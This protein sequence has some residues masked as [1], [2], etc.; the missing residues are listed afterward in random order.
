MPD[1]L[2]VCLQ[3]EDKIA[4]FAIDA[5]S[6]ALTRQTDL[7]VA[8][9]P[10]VL[11]LSP[12]RHILHVGTRSPGAILSFRIDPRTGALDPQGSVAAADAPTFLATDRTGRYLLSAYY[13]G[14]YAAVH[15]LG[16]DGAVGAPLLDRH[17]TAIG[18]HAIA[19]DPSN[20]FA[21]VPHISRVQDN[22]LEPPKN[23]PGPNFI[24]QFRFD[25]ETGRLI[26]N[27]PFR[28]EQ[29]E[30]IGPRHY[31]FHPDKDLVYFSDEQGCSVSVYRLDTATGALSPVQRVGTLPDGF[32]GRNTC[33]QIHLTPSATFLYV[34][35]R[36]HNSIAGFAV[37]AAT[38]R[39]DPAGHAPTEAVPSAFGLDPGGN[40][41]FAAGT[42]TGRLAAYRIDA[43]T[44]GLT[45][46]ATHDVG[47][48]PAAVL[49]TRLAA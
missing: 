4:S 35:N 14:G 39:L 25:A 21:F 30:L 18:A 38:G 36:G 46:L 15:P 2:F 29:A 16:P 6:G 43:R 40:F 45:P 33:S 19:T 1:I 17:D 20:R 28:V 48:R 22:V 11:A 9:G 37:D 32:S 44:G 49:A 10:S 3:D 47:Q 12:N 26:P 24:A 41:L 31:C 13:Q 7:P 27:A 5:A 23:I 42:A 34:G 8:G